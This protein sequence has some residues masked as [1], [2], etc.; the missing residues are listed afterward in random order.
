MKSLFSTI[1][2]IVFLFLGADT[3]QAQKTFFELDNLSE[4]NEDLISDAD[5]VGFRNKTASMN[6][7]LDQSLELLSSKGM[8]A[9]QVEKIKE[10]LTEMPPANGSKST[11]MQIKERRYEADPNQ[12]KMVEADKDITI[13]GSELF[14]RSSMVFEPNIRIATP[15]SYIVGPDDELIVSVYGYSEMKYN[16]TINE[17]GEIYIPNV[18]PLFVGGS[19]IEQAENKIT[20]KLA[21]TIYKAIRS[22]QTKVQVRLGKIRS[23]QVTVI[24]EA[25][26][27]GTYTVSSLTTLYNLLYLC[28]GPGNMGSYRHIEIIRGNQL[29]KTADL[30]DFLT[31]GDQKDN[32]IL[33]EGDLIRVPYYL[34]RVGISGGVK[35]TGKYEMIAGEDV[36]QLL[37]Y[38]GGFIENAYQGSITLTRLAEKEKK[39]YDIQSV[40]MDDFLVALGD[41]YYVSKI[42]GDLIDKVCVT[43][44]VYRPGNYQVDSNLTIYSLLLKVGGIREDAYQERANIFRIERGKKLS[45]LSV[46]LDSIL[47]HG[48]NLDLKKGD[49]IHIY[50]VDDFKDKVYVTIFGNV[51]KTGNIQWRSMMTVKELLL[52]AGGINDFGDSTTIE[53]SRRKK[54]AELGKNSYT[55]TETFLVNVSKTGKNGDDIVINPFDIVNVKIIPGVI[56]QRTV[57]ILGEI[58]TPGKYN[59]QNSNDRITNII[60]RSGGFKKTADSTSLIIRRKKNSSFTVQEKELLYQR[61]LNID[62]DSISSSQQLRNELYGD[63]DLII[64]DLSIALKNKNKFDN[65]ILEDGDILTVYK[66]SNLIKVSGEVYYP[67]IISLKKNKS[68]K[69]YIKQA[70]GFMTTARKVKTLV[71]Y[72]TGKVRPVR[73]FFGIKKYPRINSKAEIFV[74]QKNKENNNRIGLPELALIVSALGIIS[75]VI[76]NTIK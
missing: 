40:M 7:T 20:A 73:S 37:Q 67:A 76:I 13:F 65:L 34:N 53:I 18:G 38:C 26:K 16:L 22:G 32:I 17:N 44:S 50:G 46:S 68:A 62:H 8:P 3:A 59:L 56:N 19:S 2:L 21:S 12:N 49:S 66:K 51:R 57:M 4:I 48:V 64:V 41:D 63:Y 74:P 6:L 10:R 35:R 5:L 60:E 75:N 31:K 47:N 39:V 71:I 70:G 25:Y 72:S 28:G 1:G 42:Q 24:G 15:S 33:R 69:Y 55:E 36:T 9:N 14:L 52:E 23:I 30:Y 61:L 43:G 54:K 27:P 45:I 11:P 29:F 58:L